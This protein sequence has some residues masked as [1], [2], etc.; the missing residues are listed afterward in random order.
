MPGFLLGYRK[1][2]K[3]FSVGKTAISNILKDRKNLRRDCE[4]FKGSYK[5]RRHGKYRVINEILY[6]WYEKHTSS[7]V[8]PDAPLFEEE[9]MK[10]A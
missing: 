9:A 6:K 3:H 10:I 5:K 2:A 1:L 7:N 4:F 8:Y